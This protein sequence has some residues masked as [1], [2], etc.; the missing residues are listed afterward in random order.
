MAGFVKGSF[1]VPP[2]PPPWVGIQQAHG[3]QN[4]YRTIWEILAWATAQVPIK[5]LVAYE[6][7]D[8]NSVR[9]LRAAGGRLRPATSAIL[10]AEKQLQSSAR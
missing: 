2:R 9:G 5:G 10:K 1:A 6:G 7:G 3:E 4:Q 8:Y